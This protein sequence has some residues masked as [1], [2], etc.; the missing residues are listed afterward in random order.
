MSELAEATKIVSSQAA[1]AGIGIDE[2][3]AAV[4]T[5]IATTQQGGEVAARSLKGILMNLQA[6]KGTAEEI[7]D[8]GED[9]TDESLT[10]YEKA[11]A[12]LGV[13]LKEVKDGVLQ[14]R[15]PMEILEELANA[16]SN[17]AEGSIKVANLVSAIGGKYRGAQLLALLRNWE[18]YSKMLS[19]FNSQ[20]AVGSAFD[21]SMK[22]A[23]SW[24]GKLNEL[25]NTW[26]D[27]VNGFVNSDSMKGAID[28]ITSLIKSV[29]KLRDTLGTLPTIL[30]GVAT[31]LSF[32]NVGEL[33]NKN[34]PVS[35]QPQIIC[36]EDVT[37]FKIRLSNCWDD[38]A[39]AL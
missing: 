22:S 35:I 27:F 3:T 6:V 19:E 21:E 33:Q 20:E 1:Q 10:K 23:E 13:S 15:D 4:G 28:F 37:R 34:T 30:G 38:Y 18:T 5:M 9:I 25:S 29:D 8:G 36:I 26:T 39:K 2:M 7:G 24:E 14:L 11:C 31:A 12:D 16:V 17:E 32:K